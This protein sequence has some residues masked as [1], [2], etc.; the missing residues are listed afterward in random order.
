M[1]MQRRAL[2][3]LF[4]AAAVCCAGQGPSS[5][6]IT[7]TD[8]SGAAIP[9]AQVR[10]ANGREIDAVT[11]QNGSA[12]VND[13][14]PGTYEIAA[15]SSG[16]LTAKVS[17]ITIASGTKREVL[18][19]LEETP[20]NPVNILSL[21]SL[22]PHTYDKLLET[23]KEPPLCKEGVK[24][25]AQSYIFLWLPTFEHPIFMRVNVGQDGRGTL[26]TKT[27]SG[28][29]GY[30]LGKLETTATRKL[31]RDEEVELFSTLADI[32]FWTL[33]A[34]V[35]NPYELVLDGTT[36]VIEGVRDGQCH[37]VTRESSPLTDVF[38]HYFL[39]RV[40]KIQPY[41]QPVQQ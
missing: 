31:S 32:G 40:G 33:P 5:I 2:M 35:K 34:S 13:L 24:G 30:D 22:D 19:K 7:V 12:S 6:K 1:R 36:W 15:A 9:H 18:L 39:G 21:Q 38:T 11:D 29:G 26:S 27:L 23:F 20:P 8:L 4:F 17:G 3:F 14:S 41:Y 28:E 10:V 16:F 37:T 25:R